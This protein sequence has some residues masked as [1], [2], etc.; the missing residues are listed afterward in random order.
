MGGI[1]VQALWSRR[2]CRC[3]GSWKATSWATAPSDSVMAAIAL[4]GHGTSYGGIESLIEGQML[5]FRSWPSGA[6]L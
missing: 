6:P 4:L 2:A 3:L 5:Q 1:G